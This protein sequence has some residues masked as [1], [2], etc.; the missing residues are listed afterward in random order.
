[1]YFLTLSPPEVQKLM[2]LLKMSANILNIMQ[3]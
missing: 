3:I 1:M 2:F